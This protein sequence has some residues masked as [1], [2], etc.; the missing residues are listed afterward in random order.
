LASAWFS[1]GVGKSLI[2]TIVAA[3]KIDDRLRPQI[4]EANEY[5]LFEGPV[6]LHGPEGDGIHV[7][8][9]TVGVR[10]LFFSLK[11]QNY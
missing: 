11:F 10:H 4:I 8:H 6:D 5:Y 1:G 7:V 2:S 3:Y 9:Q